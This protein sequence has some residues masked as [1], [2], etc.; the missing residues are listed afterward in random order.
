MKILLE[1]K[2]HHYFVEFDETDY[3]CMNCGAKKVWQE[4]VSDEMGPM[5]L[6][7]ACN[8]KFTV[9]FEPSTVSDSAY[10]SLIEQLRD[11]I[12]RVPT[13]KRGG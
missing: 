7:L 9:S 8:C 3:H 13:T 10:V 11:G 6:C 12:C 1:F 2:N 4:L 5:H